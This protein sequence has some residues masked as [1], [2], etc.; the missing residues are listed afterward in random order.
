M[1]IVMSGAGAPTKAAV[2]PSPAPTVDLITHTDPS[3]WN[4]KNGKLQFDQGNEQRKSYAVAAAVTLRKAKATPGEKDQPSEEGRAFVLGDSD[5][6]SDLIIVN[7]ANAI[8]T[9]DAVRW[10]LGETEVSGIANNEE[11]VPVRHTRK[12]DVVW[13]YSSVFLAPVLVLLA[14]WAVTHKRRKWDKA[15]D[16]REVQ[17]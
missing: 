11:D 16:S 13:F 2:P 15:E 10:L 7:R 12:Q 9:L 8:L 3:T 6:L 14:G 1:P 5:A 4:D 17:P